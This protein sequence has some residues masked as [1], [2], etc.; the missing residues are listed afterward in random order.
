MGDIRDLEC[1]IYEEAMNTKQFL[2]SESGAFSRYCRVI[3]D[4]VC[5]F[6]E[7]DIDQ[8]P[9]MAA[10]PFWIGFLLDSAVI[11]SPSTPYE[12]FYVLNAGDSASFS[13]R[14]KVMT[15]SEDFAY[16]R[17]RS[18]RR[19]YNESEFERVFLGAVERSI[20]PNEPAVL[21]LSGGKD[22]ASIAIGLAEVMPKESVT[23]ITYRSHNQD[24]SLIAERIARKF[25]FE[26][27]VVDVKNYYVD[28]DQLIRFFSLQLIPS[29][30]LCATIYLHCGLEKF[31]RATLVD[32]MG[33]DLFIGH[34][35]AVHEYKIA[36]YQ[37]WIPYSVKRILGYA[38][39]F[40]R[41]VAI[42]TKTRA[43]MVGFWSFLSASSVVDCISG[44]E[45][46]RKYWEDL[47]KRLASLDY[48]DLRGSLRGRYIDQEKFIRKVKNGARM[49]DMQ[50]SLPW[51][52]S[53]L[54]S[55][56]HNLRDEDLFDKG[57]LLNKIFL[58]R[59]LSRKLS[60]DYF[61]EPKYTFAYDY[62]SF[63]IDN[64][65]FVRETIE[66]SSLCDKKILIKALKLDTKYQN[67]GAVYQLF[68]VSG[69]Y[70]YSK[71]IRR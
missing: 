62:K 2:S 56:V 4:D 12:D 18:V 51:T 45:I 28:P 31:S 63:V 46:R 1:G 23:C 25:G 58:R 69:W 40:D 27:V 29:M 52:E 43:E 17:A 14:T 6:E 24:E 35:P 39:R 26:H 37:R 38:R 42:G 61:K 5:I 49:F 57:K 65:D 48:L 47:D 36:E 34:I 59:F 70:R 67:Y 13:G 11:P 19:S 30:D 8:I 32:G 9:P 15:F 53:E 33:N 10:D 20:R 21:F 64:F 44:Y 68:L 22:S 71:F 50:L 7:K 60:M 16:S 3:G 41:R 66:N 55:Y 54:A